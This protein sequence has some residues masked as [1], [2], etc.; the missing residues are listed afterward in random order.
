MS[1]SC[2]VRKSPANIYTS[3]I[4]GTE[5]VICGNIY[6]YTHTHIDGI[7]ISGERVLEFEGG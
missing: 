7:T 5:L 4:I 1:I 2:P 6:I 3:N